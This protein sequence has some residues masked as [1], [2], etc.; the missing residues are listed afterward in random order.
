MTDETDKL[1]GTVFEGGEDDVSFQYYMFDWDD[2]IL[3]MPTK[4]YLEKKTDDGW[5]SHPVSTGQFALI[6]QDT[7][8]YRPVNDS[9]D[10]AFAE[11]Y[12]VGQRGE[13]AFI[14]DTIAALDPIVSGTAPA[15]PY[16]PI[17]NSGSRAMGKLVP[18]ACVQPARSSTAAGSP[19]AS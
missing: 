7:L 13:R 2:N 15:G 6:R 12:D 4:I 1:P 11:F 8:N 14:E 10:D 9:W 17:W 5:E 19:P 18:N 16:R 3:H